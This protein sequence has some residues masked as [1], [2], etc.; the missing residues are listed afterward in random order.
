MVLQIISAGIFLSRLIWYHIDNKTKELSVMLIAAIL[1]SILYLP[2]GVIF[3]LAQKY[4]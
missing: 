4:K 3:G 1:L 2:L